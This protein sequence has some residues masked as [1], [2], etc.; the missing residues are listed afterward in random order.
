MDASFL[1]SSYAADGN[2]D[3]AVRTM[4]TAEDIFLVTSFCELEVFN[5]L[6]LRLFR[7]E[8]SR[9]VVDAC[10]ENFRGD[11]RAGV[12]DLRAVP[13]SAFQRARGLSRQSTA[14]L[15][16]RASNLLHVACALELGASGFYSFD[17]QQRKLAESVK[18]RVNR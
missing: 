10:A 5:A 17:N 2:F 15:G 7:K 4:E 3:S 9:E 8:M 1:V 11:L 12:F 14:R 18:L 6:E 16:T 13:E